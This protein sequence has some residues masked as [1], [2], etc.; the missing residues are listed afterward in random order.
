MA[1]ARLAE[2]TAVTLSPAMLERIRKGWGDVPEIR[3]LLIDMAEMREE[4]MRCGSWAV[5]DRIDGCLPKLAAQRIR[6]IALRAC[7]PEEAEKY[8]IALGEREP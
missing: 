3:L 1:S 2:R 4:L 5:S 8:R 6:D 7:W